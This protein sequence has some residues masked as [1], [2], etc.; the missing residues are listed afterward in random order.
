MYKSA[1]KTDPFLMPHQVKD[2]GQ[3]IRKHKYW[4]TFE[5]LLFVTAGV[6]AIALP[7]VT[8]LAAEGIIGAV[9]CLGGLARLV[10][11]VRFD[12]G[13]GWR[14]LSGLIFLAAGGSMLWWPA[15]GINTLVVIIGIFLFAEGLTEIF[16]S[17][18][19]RPLFHWG[20]LFI[21]GI[22]S[23]ILGVLIFAF[24]ITGIIF[25]A[26]AI[27]LSMIFHGLSLLV[28]TWKSTSPKN[29]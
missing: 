27:G 13:R 5:G 9:L 20:A 6:L 7:G 19:Y 12:A 2:L 8:T 1:L 22:M 25:I 11:S 23:L 14:L 21:S 26:L 24:P 29:S 28:F 15:E 17:L 10:N 4:Y 18:T 3:E 16:L